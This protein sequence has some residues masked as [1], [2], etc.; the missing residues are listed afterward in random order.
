MQGKINTKLHKL[1]R[2]TI[3]Y[4]TY[5]YLK[6]R[7]ANHIQRKRS[8]KIFIKEFGLLKKSGITTQNR[9]ILD[10]EDRYPCHDDK[11]KYTSYDRHYVLHPA[12]AARIL[13]KLKPDIHYDISSTL[14]FGSIVSAFIK[15]KF[16]DYRPAQLK[17]SDFESNHADLLKLPFQSNSIQSLSCMHT[18][19][20]IGLGRYGDPLDYDGD[21]KAINELTRVLGI[22]GNLLV[23]VPIAAE[24]RIYFNAHRVYSASQFISY[25][26][27]LEL[28]E[29]CLIPDKESDADFMVN[30][31]EEILAKSI[32]DCGCFWFRKN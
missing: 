27:E 30:P 4:S 14:Y 10:W 22:G 28:V 1:L 11:T 13:N 16:F 21:I 8:A 23:V 20:H 17:I 25:F 18:L 7:A 5:K 26:P 32:Y 31:S 6:I 2:K 9:F 24:P 19:E 3:F 12:W 29:F 15:I